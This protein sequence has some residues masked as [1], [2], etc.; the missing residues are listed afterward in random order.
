[1]PSTPRTF[2]PETIHHVYNRGTQKMTVFHSSK[3]YERFYEKMKLYKEKYGVHI[4]AWSLMPNH[5][6]LLLQVPE[7]ASEKSLSQF[8][9]QLQNAY[10]KY[11]ATSYEFSG[12]LFQGTFK[13]KLVE[14]EEYFLSML[15]YVHKQASHHRVGVADKNSNP[16]LDW[17]YTS[18]HDYF[19]RSSPLFRIT[20]LDE[21]LLDIHDYP[22]LF[23]SY[24]E[25]LQI[26][27]TFED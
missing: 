17:P 7:N 24:K 25:E 15:H 3:D 19:L 14:T 18:L 23:A 8:M 1:M 2:L 20:D 5:F 11:Y 4:L 16:D 26:V 12:R 27:W 10:A 13:S 22:R 9:Q 21:S 6:H